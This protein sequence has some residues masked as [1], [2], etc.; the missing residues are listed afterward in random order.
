MSRSKTFFRKNLYLLFNVVP[1]KGKILFEVFPHCFYTFLHVRFVERLK[2]SLCLLFDLFSRIKSLALKS[3]FQGNTK[4]CSGAMLF[5]EKD[6][7]TSGYSIQSLL[8]RYAN[9][10]CNCFTSLKRI[11]KHD[12]MGIP[13]N[14]APPVILDGFRLILTNVQIVY[15]ALLDRLIHCHK[16]L[17]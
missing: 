1:F 8:I 14:V 11:Y 13:K 16:S 10:C 2:I 4:E 17:H 7:R 6:F 5:G 15:W 12:S 9:L 3:F